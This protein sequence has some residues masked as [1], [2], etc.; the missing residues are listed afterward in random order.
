MSQTKQTIKDFLKNLISYN[1]LMENAIYFILLITL[2]GIGLINP[3]F[4]SLENLSTILTQSSTKIIFALGSAGI[5]ILG[6]IDLSIGRLVGLAAVISCSFLQSTT[7]ERRIFE[8][9]EVLPVIIPI[10]LAMICCSVISLISGLVTTKWN[11][12][13]FIVTLGMSEIVYG[14]CSLYYGVIAHS[15]PIGGLDERFKDLVATGITI[16]GVP[17]NRLVF[18]TIIVCVIMWIIWNKT[19]IGK[20]MYAIGGNK[21][22][23]NISGVNVNKNIIF[24][25]LIAGI[26]YGFGGALEGARTGSATNSLGASYALDAIAACVVGGVSLLGGTGNVQGVVLGVIIFQVINYGLI[27]IGVSPDLHYI[28]KGAIIICAVAIDVRK[29]TMRR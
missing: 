28:V 22:A 16:F 7:Y 6:G 19:V 1:F 27:Y 21:N 24:I 11:V 13:S 18:Y 25:F 20:N 12:V 10:L 15:T 29:Y 2:I 14:L 17:I 9:M 23:A 5:M 4:F 8:G 3:S 26:L